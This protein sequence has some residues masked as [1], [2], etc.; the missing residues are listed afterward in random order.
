MT[1]EL[2]SLVEASTKARTSVWP[3]IIPSIPG[4]GEEGCGYEVSDET[5]QLIVAVGNLMTPLRFPARHCSE[6]DLAVRKAV[7]DRQELILRRAFELTTDKLQAGMELA[8][9]GIFRFD[10]RYKSI[11][12]LADELNA[13]K[14]IRTLVNRACSANNFHNA[15]AYR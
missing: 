10:M 12:W 11:K 9:F 4:K 8:V 7:A 13:Q 5:L 14:A 1:I 2:V 15:R 3:I 6:L